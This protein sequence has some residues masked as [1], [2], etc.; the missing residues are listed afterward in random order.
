MFFAPVAP[1]LLPGSETIVPLAST[2]TVRQIF[3]FA[4]V[5]VKLTGSRSVP[6]VALL[7]WFG[8]EFSVMGCGCFWA[9]RMFLLWPSWFFAALFSCGSGARDGC[10]SGLSELGLR[11]RRQGR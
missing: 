8:F 3:W 5:A 11:V 9:A 7:S 1:R 2:C 10:C 4:E 6:A